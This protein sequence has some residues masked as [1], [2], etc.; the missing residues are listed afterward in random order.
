MLYVPVA[1]A[2]LPGLIHM[3]ASGGLG[4]LIGTAF[5]IVSQIDARIARGMQFSVICSEDA[6][7]ITDADVKESSSNS[8]YGDARV[9]PTLRAC[10]YWAK[11]K[12]PASF[13]DPVKSDKP[14][15]LISGA[16]DPVTPPRLAQTVVKTLPNGRLIIPQNAT[17]ASYGCIEGLMAAFIERGSAERLNVSCV[18]QI[19]RPPFTIIPTQ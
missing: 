3:A 19:R 8:F 10:R 15:L 17:H 11:A 18:D 12:V 13:L 2:A 1:A 16:L 9:R 4:P 5:Q 6:P 7:F 14:V